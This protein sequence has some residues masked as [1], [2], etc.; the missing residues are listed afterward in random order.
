MTRWLTWPLASAP[1][2]RRRNVGIM[3]LDED[4]LTEL[5]ETK[6]AIDQLQERLKDLVAQLRD[7][8]ATAQEIA[9]A[10]RGSP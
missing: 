8:G 4:L 10:L 2:R 9:A 3:P 1:R 7:R 6:A 5:R